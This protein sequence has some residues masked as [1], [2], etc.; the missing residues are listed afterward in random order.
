M[1]KIAGIDSHIKIVRAKLDAHGHDWTKIE[2]EAIAKAY[3][4]ITKVS[5]TKG[6]VL[7]TG[8]DSCVMSAVNIV[9]NYL[10]VIGEPVKDKAI[11]A[12]RKI[13]EPATANDAKKAIDTGRAALNQDE[14]VSKDNVD[15]STANKEE[16][17]M[18]F[19]PT[20]KQWR[21]NLDSISAAAKELEFTF[22][23]KNVTKAQRI[24]ALEAHMKELNK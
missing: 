5:T 10:A 1:E 8:C 20:D 23:E 11:K 6:R 21:K 24:A 4:E 15:D 13:A 17:E 22:D 2:K 14:V 7:D 12:A 19:S 9:K 16:E 18:I 3:F